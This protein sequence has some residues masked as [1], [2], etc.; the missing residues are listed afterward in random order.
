MVIRGFEGESAEGH[1]TRRIVLVMVRWVALSAV[2]VAGGTA[3]W[4]PAPWSWVGFL[5]SLAAAGGICGIERHRRRSDEETRRGIQELNAEIDALLSREKM[6]T[7]LLASLPVGVVAVRRGMPVYANRAAIEFLGKRVVEVGAPM[8]TEVRRVIDEARQ[9]G[10]PSRQ[11][12][13]GY[14]RRIIE[15]SSHPPGD[16]DLIVLYLVDITERA[17]T[18]RMRQDFVA[19]ASHELK[20]PVAAIQAAAE[21]V[22]VALDDDLDVVFEFS[23]R[24]FDNALRMS[25]IV[26][27]LLDLSRLESDALRA[28]PFDLAD[29]LGEEV[30]RF[31]SSRPS[32]EFEATP[33]PMVGNPSDLAL[34]FRNLLENAVRHT[35]DDGWVR[36]S[37][38]STDDEA[39]VV[40][41]DSGAGIP[42]A[43]LPRIFERFYRADVARSR[44][45]GGTGLGLA[46]VKHV[47]DLHGGRVEV[48]SRLGEGS[49]FR[50]R[51]PAL[52][53]N[54]PV[55]RSAPF[56]SGPRSERRRLPHRP[57][58]G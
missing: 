13:Q 29:V 49:T 58:P 36:A 20:T 57:P 9:G 45:T 23:G 24:I 28:E 34:A 27:N 32:I 31:S 42:A 21:T 17:Q 43:D 46:I 37:V 52:P 10:S 33:T 35:P 8:P 3:L 55:D 39:A 1:R 15:V 30:Q 18:D 53:H 38:F 22:L 19:A 54:H 56:R 11:F 47:A 25:R 41:V 48:E 40:V 7:A 4:A 5:A 14:P 6:H 26:G 50:M 44:A 51:V 16:D 2:V 12:V